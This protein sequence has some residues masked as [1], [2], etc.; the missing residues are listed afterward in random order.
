MTQT[1]FHHARPIYE[2][3]PGWGEDISRAS[4]FDDLPK[5]ARDYVRTLEELAGVPVAA[6][7]VGP[8]RNQTISIR[9]LV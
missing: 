8:G 5:A 7:G 4:S 1:E 3:L 2:E 9:D 6:V